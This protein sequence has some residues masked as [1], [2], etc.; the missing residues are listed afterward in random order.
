MTT[1]KIKSNPL[2]KC[3][4]AFS[5][6]IAAILC[7]VIAFAPVKAL[8]ATNPAIA[9][10]TDVLEA[11]CNTEDAQV[12]YFGVGTGS[13]EEYSS[14]R[15]IGPY[16]WY[17]IGYDGSGAASASGAITLFATENFG[18][19]KF[20]DSSITSNANVYANSMLRERI[21]GI[22]ATELTSEE[23][24]AVITRTLE[25]GKFIK[26]ASSDPKDYHEPFCDGVAGEAVDD[27]YMWPLSTQEA[28]DV[29]KEKTVVDGTSW[30]YDGTLRLAEKLPVEVGDSNARNWW[31][32][33]PGQSDQQVATTTGA[34]DVLAGGGSAGY[35]RGIRP[36]FYLDMDAVLFVSAAEGGKPDSTG[37][38]SEVGTNDTGEW[39]LTLLESARAFAV[40][41]ASVSG[42]PG[43]TV[44][45]TYT[46]ATV[47]VNDY[48]S[49]IIVDGTGNVIYYGKLDQASSSDG[50]VAVPI[51]SDFA[52]GTYT[53]KLFNESCNGD[54]MTD[55]AS[56]FSEV[57]LVVEAAPVEATITFDLAGGTLDGK[58]GT[59]TVTAIVGETI[60]LLDAPVR[61]GYT[62]KYWKGSEY[63][64]GVEYV[65]EG[66][67]SFTA[68]WEKN[69]PSTI[70]ATG[71]DSGMVAISFAI[72]AFGSLIALSACS[73]RRGVRGRRSR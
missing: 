61:D 59:I 31:L 63:K 9:L 45:L 17:V 70:P 29:E 66:D 25:I 32:R 71:D 67:H 50:T 24:N 57:E 42:L 7:A 48:I 5:L 64:A 14:M 19:A 6:A 4:F 16:S 13:D 49:A 30:K 21:D 18:S 28:W 36:A 52:I 60:N 62:F 37:S 58:T 3:L 53:L 11:G 69:T 39:K 15:W 54:Y 65:V 47:G 72:A 33:S 51:P 35:I 44:D 22:A 56:D 34:G 55:Y 27:A 46:G 40:N 43:D 41:E 23:L 2:T 12:V 38:L 8:A 1:S 20:R 26:Y 73:S 68:E 10:G